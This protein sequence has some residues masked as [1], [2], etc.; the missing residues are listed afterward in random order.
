[1]PSP[2]HIS[3]PPSWPITGIAAPEFNP[4]P[5]GPRVQSFS[6]EVV[7]GTPASADLGGS[8][9]RHVSARVGH[10]SLDS[11][12]HGSLWNRGGDAS[13]YSERQHGDRR[14]RPTG[15]ELQ[16]RRVALLLS[17]IDP[18]QNRA[19]NT[20]VN[21]PGFTESAIYSM[22]LKAGPV[23]SLNLYNPGS[24][25][26]CGAHW[27]SRSQRRPALSTPRPA[28]GRRRAA[29]IDTDSNSPTFRQVT[30]LTTLV[31]GGNG[32]NSDP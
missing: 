15:R 7:V 1:M 31:T 24:G 20:A 4:P 25:Y 11:G 29:D 26:S 13:S 6:T 17:E 9:A 30:G 14:R 18:S 2:Q 27:L 10:A 16:R 22:N 19:V 21:T 28:F 23:V 12:T 3:Q 5:Q 8:S 32:Y